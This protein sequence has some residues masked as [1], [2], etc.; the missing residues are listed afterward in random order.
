MRQQRITKYELSQVNKFIYSLYIIYGHGL[1]WEECLEVSLLEYAE[2]RHD[3]GYIYNSD[4][5][6]EVARRRIVNAIK[7]VR[8]L[9]NDKISLQGK[10]SL[11]QT[12]GESDEPVYNYLFP[13]QGDFTNAV[14]MWD[15]VSRLG[16]KKQRVARMLYQG[17]DDLDI[18]ERLHM[19]RDEYYEIK[20][21]LQNDMK[22]Y[23]EI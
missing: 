19:G 21:Q 13:V 5:L 20:L 16:K 17:E 6:W 18:I 11:N 9:R 8:K 15:F 2:A 22:V 3:L 4:T 1:S 12:I 7:K 23:M 10:L 14:C